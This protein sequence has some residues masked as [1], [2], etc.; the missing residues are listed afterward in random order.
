MKKQ[1]EKL[2]QRSEQVNSEKAQTGLDPASPH[3]IAARGR[4]IGSIPD[5]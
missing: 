3:P 2:Q 1:K 4:R 5:V